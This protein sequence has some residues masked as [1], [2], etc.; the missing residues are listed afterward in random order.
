[1]RYSITPTLLNSWLYMM[2]YEGEKESKVLA[3]FMSTLRRE[4]F[5]DN[6]AMRKGR[7][8][9]A[10]IEELCKSSLTIF[11]DDGDKELDCQLEIMGIVKVGSWQV[12]GSKEITVNEV[13]YLLKGRCD[14]LKGP[15]IYD[16]KRVGR[17]EP[18][19]YFHSAQH[20]AYFEIFPGTVEFQ[21]LVCPGKDAK[22]V[23]VETYH[24]SD[25]ESIKIVIADFQ[26]WL[27]QYPERKAVYFDKWEVVR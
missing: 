27:E 4:P 5:K 12:C 11:P 26:G 21:Y 1:M 6:E 20:K 17:Y 24:R 23:C 22:E 7:K 19:K 10:D 25:T 16:I 2:S 13:D 9:E 15:T 3:E 18:G 8:F 14:V